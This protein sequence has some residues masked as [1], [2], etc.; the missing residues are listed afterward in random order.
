MNA[1]TPK[2]LSH[3]ALM[4][5]AITGLLLLG[6]VLG[7]SLSKLTMQPMSMPEVN[8]AV[9]PEPKVLYWYD[10]MVP[11]QHFDKPGKS[12]F[13]DM[14]LVAKMAD[15]NY[16]GST[17]KMD[18]G[19]VQNWGMRLAQVER[20]PLQTQVEVTGQL[21]FNERHQARVQ[22]RST[23]FVERVWPLA[24]GDSVTQGQAIAEFLFPEWVS[25]QYDFLALKQANEPHL[26]DAARTRLRL[27]GMPE[28]L[29]AT[30]EH[31]NKVELHFII[32]APINGIIEALEVKKGMTLN[33]GQDVV[34]INGLD[35]LW[36]DAAIPEALLG[37]S[38]TTGQFQAGDKA[39]FYPA[40]SSVMPLMGTVASLLPVIDANSR[41]I[42]A[43]VVLPNPS[44]KLRPG[45]SGRVV[46]QHSTPDTGLVIPTEA[47]I[48]TGKRTLVMVSM[49]AGQFAPVEI[50]TGMEIGDKT[51]VL[52]GLD[53][54]QNV[55]ASGQ[56]LIDS[57][58]SLLGLVP[59]SE[60][61]V[62][63]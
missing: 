27:L 30:I 47:I 55:V 6:M 10:P 51:V 32:T 26:I 61:G 13:M 11:T 1:S 12:P 23:G 31:N 40:N 15:E 8:D 59:V 29:I 41:T 24:V 44:G 39:T 22:M 37:T 42:M 58:A 4:I 43:R 19:T 35:D 18:A 46:L 54:G 33:S 56:F 48:R 7:I 28:T 14:D 60:A 16:E 5:L 17:L 62:Q 57:E 2:S 25:A 52:E 9:T 34:R 21:R 20:V 45:M 36:L 38:A 3:K 63:P 50:H 53:E 49:A